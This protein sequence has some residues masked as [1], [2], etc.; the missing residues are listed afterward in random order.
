MVR[1]KLESR[2]LD[3]VREP[4]QLDAI[5]VVDVDVLGLSDGK[6]R[7]VLQKPGGR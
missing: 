5:L 6:H 7:V 1:Q 3:V 4:M 2:R